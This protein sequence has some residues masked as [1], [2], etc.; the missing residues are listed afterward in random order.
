[1]PKCSV[2]SKKI[3]LAMVLAMECHGCH[4]HCCSSGCHDSHCTGCALAKS[5]EE[6]KKAIAQEKLLKQ[7]VTGTKLER[8]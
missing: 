4:A 3:Q 8:L 5:A 6:A 7:G 1:M 2:C